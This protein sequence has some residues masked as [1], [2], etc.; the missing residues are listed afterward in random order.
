MTDRPYI[1]KRLVLPLSLSALASLAASYFLKELGHDLFVN[2]AA[3]FVG[4]IL[5][6]AYVDR[7]LQRR[8]ELRWAGLRSRATKRLFAFANSCITTVRLA[9][10]IRA[11]DIEYDE[12]PTLD[13]NIMRTRMVRVAQE[14]LPLEISQIRNMTSEQWRRFHQS[15]Q[16]SHEIGDRLLLLFGKDFAPRIP[17]LVLDIQSVAQSLMY[18]YGTWPDLMGVPADRLP[19]RRDGSST[20]PLQQASYTLAER[21]TLKLL[22]FLSELLGELD[23]LPSDPG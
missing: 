15:L 18:H 5:T 3:T 12:E 16:V 17:E 7:V 21:D 11:R 23:E 4:S 19:H 2:L 1:L 22:Q 14:I 13:L 20:L 10:N 9:L 6:V 8:Q